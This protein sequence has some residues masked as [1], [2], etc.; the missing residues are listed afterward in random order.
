[1]FYENKRN[2]IVAILAIALLT[3]INSLHRR[4]SCRFCR[5]HHT[6][7]VKAGGLVETLSEQDHRF[8]THKRCF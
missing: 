7:A 6:V 5:S 8:C 1:M 3:G 2:F 4:G